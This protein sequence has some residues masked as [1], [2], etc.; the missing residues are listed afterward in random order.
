MN[1]PPYSS[2]AEYWGLDKSVVFLNHGSFGACPLPVLE[3]QSE[4]RR[5]IES[6][7]VRFFLR[8]APHL[9][10]KSRKKLADFVSCSP[11]NLVFVPNATTGINTILKSLKFQRG[12][13][14]LITNHI[15]PACRNAVNE[16]ALV[17]HLEIKEV[18][19]SLPVISRSDITEKILS[20]ISDSTKVILLD[21][22]S[23]IPGIIFP[24]EEI[25]S[26]LK[27]RDIEIIID[28]AHAPGMIPLNISK[29]EARYYTGNCH[30]WICSPKG[31]AFLYVSPERQKN[32]RPLVRSR[33][34]GECVTELSEFIYD[35]SWQGTLDP[36]P[37]ICISDALEF[38]NSL[39]PGGWSELMNHNKTLALTAGKKICDAFGIT[40]PCPDNVIGSLYG[41]PF[42]VDKEIFP[43]TVNMRSPLQDDLFYK[44][45]I[46][47]VISYWESQP[48]RILR[49]SPQIYN[50]LEQYEYLITA[51][52]WLL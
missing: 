16:V 44:Y 5:R 15:Y 48:E 49:I 41:I 7:P 22:V 2:Y 6:E 42:F 33:L 10:E 34:Y 8:E 25:C 23:S 27:N 39:L 32:I 17:N 12:S 46:E 26:E 38:M 4:Y 35:F 47:V 29:M 45:K 37:Y 21:H 24:V 28:G 51:L 50:T 13:E 1:L 43:K 18:K 20:S 30:K 9:L 11:D 31:S 3:K 40:N 36:T 52:K 14:I 19:I